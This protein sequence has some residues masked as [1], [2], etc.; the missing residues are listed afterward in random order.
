[1]NTTEH[2]TKAMLATLKANRPTSVSMS[3]KQAEDI[4]T[5]IEK[6]TR[7]SKGVVVGFIK[8]LLNEHPVNRVHREELQFQKA[9]KIDWPNSDRK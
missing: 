9:T 8:Q 5:L 2:S 7:I 3:R 6:D 4:I 1:M